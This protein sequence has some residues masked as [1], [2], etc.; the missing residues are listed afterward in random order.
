MKTKKKQKKKSILARKAELARQ[1]RRRKKLYIQDLEI[2]VKKLGLKIEELQQKAARAEAKK[3]PVNFADEETLRRERQE[4]IRRKLREIVETSVAKQQLD[5]GTSMQQLTSLVKKFVQNSRERQA[6]VDFYMDRVYDCL[7]PGTQVKFAMWGLDQS[8][9]FY[10][11]KDGLWQS[12]M[13]AIGLNSAQENAM[14]QLRPAMHRERVALQQAQHLLKQC[15]LTVHTHLAQ[16]YA[17]IDR[18]Q[19]LLSPLQLARLYLWVENNE[20]C[21]QMLNTVFAR[22]P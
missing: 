13:Q 6:K 16:L 5:A 14:Q 8:D 7:M 1:S 15:R 10:G 21:L 11:K 12:L 18:I 22:E 4:E 17:L 3:T 19:T 9:E 2:K 20:W